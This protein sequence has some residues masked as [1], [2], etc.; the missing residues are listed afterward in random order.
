MT[1]VVS[2]S[3]STTRETV[4]PMTGHLT[5]LISMIDLHR[6]SVE[7]STGEPPALGGAGF[8]ALIVKKPCHLPYLQGAC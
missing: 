2:P 3:K 8:P 1:L 5:R 7:L 4:A 6:L